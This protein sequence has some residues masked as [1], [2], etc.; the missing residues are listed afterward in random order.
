MLAHENL[1]VDPRLEL[2]NN[3]IVEARGS[4]LREEAGGG[5]RGTGGGL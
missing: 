3:Y 1:E 2:V 4:D 5:V